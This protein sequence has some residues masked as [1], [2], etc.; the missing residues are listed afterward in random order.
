MLAKPKT[1]IL[2][3]SF[4]GSKHRKRAPV[5]AE[6]AAQTT[7]SVTCITMRHLGV[8]TQEALYVVALA[9]AMLWWDKVVTLLLYLDG[10]IKG[11]V[12]LQALLGQSL[13]LHA[14]SVISVVKAAAMRLWGLGLRTVLP[15]PVTGLIP[16][17]HQWY[18]VVARVIATRY[19]PRCLPTH[20]TVPLKGPVDCVPA[21]QDVASAF[22]ITPVVV[23]LAE[24]PSHMRH[25]TTVTGSSSGLLVTVSPALSKSMLQD[26]LQGVAHCQ[27]QYSQRLNAVIKHLF[28]CAAQDAHAGGPWMY[29]DAHGDGRWNLEARRP[30]VCKGCLADVQAIYDGGESDAVERTSLARLVKGVSDF[31]TRFE[32]VSDPGAVPS[33]G[34]TLAGPP[35]T[36]KTT[37]VH[38]LCYKFG[39]SLFVPPLLAEDAFLRLL[40]SV[41]PHSAVLLDDFDALPFDLTRARPPGKHRSPS[42]GFLQKLLGLLDGSASVAGVLFFVCTNYPDRLDGALLR[43]GRLGDYVWK[44]GHMDSLQI[45]RALSIYRPDWDMRDP[46]VVR[47]ISLLHACGSVVPISLQR[48]VTGGAAPQPAQGLRRLVLTTSLPPVRG[49]YLQNLLTGVPGWYALREDMSRIAMLPQTTPFQAIS[50]RQTMLSFF[51]LLGASVSRCRADSALEAH[52]YPDVT[53]LMP[54]QVA[55]VSGALFDVYLQRGAPP[56]ERQSFLDCAEEMARCRRWPISV[57]LLLLLATATKGHPKWYLH[58]LASVGSLN[59]AP[60]KSWAL[61]KPQEVAAMFST[62]LSAEELQEPW[63]KSFA[64]RGEFPDFMWMLRAEPLT[65][66][67]VELLRAYFGKDDS[68]TRYPSFYDSLGYMSDSIHALRTRSNAWSHMPTMLQ[69]M[70]VDKEYPLRLAPVLAWPC[71]TLLDRVQSRYQVRDQEELD[72]VVRQLC[73]PNG[74]T[75]VSEYHL[76]A[77]LAQEP[78]LKEFLHRVVHGLAFLHC[79]FAF[80]SPTVTLPIA[81]LETMGCTFYRVSHEQCAARNRSA[82]TD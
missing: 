79:S 19:A 80:A 51:A 75:W 31:V 12:L 60:R 70:E 43:E 40:A 37:T 58:F 76:E 15:A 34:M 64:T 65:A 7:A 62:P 36:L 45:Q 6:T 77:A 47:F 39:L 72:D 13:V 14:H 41:P 67:T 63:V 44:P 30:L 20:F 23:T 33:V 78:G 50:F 42:F 17:N 18:Q 68:D 54:E 81:Q 46:V 21:S 52:T 25:V 48:L 59:G 16:D 56:A 61:Y 73:D 9:V 24:D 22:G 26:A 11:N 2:E 1:A 49:A 57:K 29:Q 71:H 3:A 66:G 55:L 35:G 10:A 32:G 27:Q 69:D 28:A 74:F 8:H 38:A 53:P 4:F 5:G 82:A